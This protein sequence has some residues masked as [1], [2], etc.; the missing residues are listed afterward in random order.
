MTLEQ[1]AQSVISFPKLGLEFSFS[2]IA[3][4][5]GSLSI[6]W[7]GVLAATGFLLGGLYAF[8]YAK[9]VG[10]DG[11]RLVDVIFCGLV[12][13]LIGARL[14]YVAF[15]WDLYKGDLMRILDIRLGGIAIYGGVI[16][17][18]L[19]GMVMARMR[20]VKILPT[21]DLAAGA[22]LIGQCIGRWGNF[23][24]VEAFGSNTDSIFGM[25]GPKVVGYLT[26][27]KA[28]G[29][30]WAAGIDPN[31]PVHPTFLYESVW[32]LLGFAIMVL[33]IMKHRHF[34]GEAFLFYAAWYGAGRAVIEGLRTDSLMWNGVRVS[35]VFAVL[36]VVMALSIWFVL[37]RKKRR[38]GDAFLPL[39]INSEDGQR[40]IQGIYYQKAETP[41]IVFEEQEASEAPQA[42]TEGAQDTRENA[43]A[44]VTEQ[45]QKPE[46]TP[47]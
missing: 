20:R 45:P 3:F 46:D 17:G 29:A 33:F 30:A 2:R 39:Y 26:Q 18:I 16:G 38:L 36:C 42:E 37:L 19:G 34:D 27:V 31:M 32:C 41:E 28:S 4:S 43:S 44:E 10:V 6:Y 22:L 21:L 35:Q 8:H 23:V 15:S 40:T 12:T 14:Y 9:K 47:S 25:T 5:I 24:N 7:Y 13:G 1:L 11:D